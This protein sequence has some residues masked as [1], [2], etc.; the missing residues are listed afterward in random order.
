MLN[1]SALFE[2][3]SSLFVFNSTRDS[4]KMSAL[5]LCFFNLV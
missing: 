5:F 4:S 1:D 2:I 3:E